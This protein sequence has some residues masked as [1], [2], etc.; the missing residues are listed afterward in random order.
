MGYSSIF[1][2]RTV[3]TQEGL[4]IAY[5]TDKF[6]RI[7]LEAIEYDNLSLKE[8]NFKIGDVG[9]IL[10]LKCNKK[11]KENEQTIVVANTHL[12]R[13][14]AA[15]DVRFGQASYLLQKVRHIP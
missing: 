15:E 1:K 5:K 8:G 13:Q 7:D 12:Y 3:I 10:V 11:E 6:S 9:M 14:P 2:K 4:L